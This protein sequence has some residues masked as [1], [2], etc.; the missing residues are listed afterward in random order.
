M[1]KFSTTLRVIAAAALMTFGGLAASNASAGAVFT[2]NPKSIAPTGSTTGAGI[3]FSANQMAGISSARIVRTTG[4]NYTGSGYII[5]TSF[6]NN[7]STVSGAKSQ[8]NNSYQLYATFTQ[9]FACASALVVGT[10]C[11]VASIQLDM[12]ADQ[13][14][15]DITEVNNTKFGPATVDADYSISDNG[16]D[17]HLATVSTVMNGTAGINSL[18][19]AFQNINTNFALTA[20]GKLYFTGPPEFYNNAFSAFNNSSTGLT[21][22]PSCANPTTFAINQESGTTD[23]LSVPEPASVAL[24]GIALAGV[25]VARRR[26]TL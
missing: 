17:I 21:C 10:S 7:G 20:A 22:K 14:Y 18:G 12:F 6:A 3:I 13:D 19:G 26:K 2:V 23:F 16:T 1:K 24:F 5:Y 11:S 9:T 8:V 25:A 15:S 4:T